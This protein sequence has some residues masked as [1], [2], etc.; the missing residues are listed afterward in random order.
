VLHI[1]GD[2]LNFG[3][4]KV[5]NSSY[6][7]SA[8]ITISK[9]TTWNTQKCQETFTLLAAMHYIENLAIRKSVSSIS[10]LY[11]STN[12]P[13]TTHYLQGKRYSMESDVHGKVKFKQLS[14]KKRLMTPFPRSIA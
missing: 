2:I 1:A 12:L 14:S 6:A 10:A 4:P 11:P 5:M 8:H 9:D 13:P 3:V 7:E